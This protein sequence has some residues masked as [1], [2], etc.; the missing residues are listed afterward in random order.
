MLAVNSNLKRV[1]MFSMMKNLSKEIS[2]I[3]K[4]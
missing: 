2:N 3:Q 1:H 4:A